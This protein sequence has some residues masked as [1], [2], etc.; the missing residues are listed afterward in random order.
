MQNSEMFLDDDGQQEFGQE[1]SKVEGHTEPSIHEAS[2][3]NKI[4]LN[5]TSCK[6][7][8][9]AKLFIPFS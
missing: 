8:Q 1:P 7:S 3:N 9:S 6:A 5:A 2:L 4:K